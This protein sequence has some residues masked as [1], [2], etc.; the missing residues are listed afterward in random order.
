M[1]LSEDNHTFEYGRPNSFMLSSNPE[2]NTTT[3]LTNFDFG[4]ATNIALSLPAEGKSPSKENPATQE[5][6]LSEKPQKSEAPSDLGTLQPPQALHDAPAQPSFISHGQ[7]AASFNFPPA[8]SG[9]NLSPLGGSPTRP[10]SHSAPHPDGTNFGLPPTLDS[11]F[12]DHSM[13]P[14]FP[15]LDAH[16]HPAH[17]IGVNMAS[18]SNPLGATQDSNNTVPNGTHALPN[19]SATSSTLVPV[20]QHSGPNYTDITEY[21]NMPQN[22][23]AK[24]LNIPTSTLSKR[25]KEAVVNRKWPYRTV[26]KIDKEIMT[27]LHNIPQGP[28][29]PPLPQEIEQSLAMLL[30]RRQA[31]LR[32]VILRL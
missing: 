1:A 27:L 22:E 30:K 23:A 13:L 28:G 19:Q 7:E 14:N 6:N 10:V 18:I 9:S 32:T 15:G 4:S 8:A 20:P 25:W 29:A 17:S 5:A 2:F 3:P 12:P 24:R 16:S 21:L 31:E 11:H 26:C